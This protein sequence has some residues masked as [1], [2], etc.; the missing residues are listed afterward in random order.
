VFPD[1]ILKIYRPDLQEFVSALCESWK[2][3]R[4]LHFDDIATIPDDDN[5]DD[6][7]E[8]DGNEHEDLASDT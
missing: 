8:V 2:G 7:C 1:A 4:V 5:E 6:S 3:E